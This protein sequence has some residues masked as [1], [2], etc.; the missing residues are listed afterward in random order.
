MSS[1]AQTGANW[2]AAR[3]S[4]ALA[5]GLALVL[6]LCF[7]LLVWQMPAMKVRPQH[8]GHQRS[9]ISGLGSV[10]GGSEQE[11]PDAAVAQTANQQQKLGATNAFAGEGSCSFEAV[12]PK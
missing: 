9:L 7:G 1:A 6:I 2:A 3:R 10:L 5:L 12:S 8:V 11:F 4:I